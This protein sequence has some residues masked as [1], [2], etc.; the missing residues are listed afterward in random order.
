MTERPVSVRN[1]STIWRFCYDIFNA[2]LGR[3]DILKPA[4]GSEI[5]QENNYGNGVRVTNLP[6]Q[7]SVR[8]KHSV[9]K[10]LLKNFKCWWNRPDSFVWNTAECFFL[11][12]YKKSAKSASEMFFCDWTSV[13]FKSDHCTIAC[14]MDFPL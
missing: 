12:L 11:S 6:H 14:P 2:K 9:P 5:L 13:N 4:I 7:K 8:Q 3:E 1:W 10:W